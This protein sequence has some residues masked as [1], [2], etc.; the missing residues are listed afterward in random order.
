MIRQEAARGRMLRRCLQGALV[1]GAALLAGCANLYVE[2][3]S[4][5]GPV[6]QIARPAQ[7][8]PVQLV[9]DFQTRGMTDPGATHSRSA[10][11][12]D[13]V[14]ASGLFSEVRD[15]PADGAG[16]LTVTLNH[17]PPT[18]N[19]WAKGIATGLSLGAVGQQAADDYTCTVSYIAP[20]RSQ[21]VVKEART[22]I[23]TTV[24]AAKAPPNSWKAPDAETAVNTMVRQLLSK[25][26]DALSHDPALSQ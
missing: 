7:P 2:G 14:R 9:V 12:A 16:M 21:P 22:A 6:A 19:L 8:R 26:L 15:L 18:E 25:T 24:G 1:A 17:L 10:M 4:G 5:E 13:L 11:V 20:G 3:A 23:Y